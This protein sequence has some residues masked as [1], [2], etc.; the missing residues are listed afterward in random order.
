MRVLRRREREIKKNET[1][2]K[3]RERKREKLL[4]KFM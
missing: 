2:L 4:K 1:N 3:E